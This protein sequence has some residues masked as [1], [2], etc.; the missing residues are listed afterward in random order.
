MIVGE[1]CVEF[2]FQLFWFIIGYQEPI[3][4][5]AAKYSIKTGISMRLPYLVSKRKQCQTYEYFYNKV[6]RRLT[7]NNI[8]LLIMSLYFNEMYVTKAFLELSHVIQ[9][10][11]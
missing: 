5:S 6:M 7:K 4:H 2:R 11:A 9:V 8:L 3:E 10:F 1:K